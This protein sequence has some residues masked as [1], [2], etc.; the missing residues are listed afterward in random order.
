MGVIPVDE[1]NDIIL[2]LANAHAA[3]ITF[4]EQ[5][6]VDV[7]SYVSPSTFVLEVVDDSNNVFSRTP[8]SYYLI[9]VS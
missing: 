4:S 9:D 5:I 7:N 1:V 6:C 3:S 8:I 2:T